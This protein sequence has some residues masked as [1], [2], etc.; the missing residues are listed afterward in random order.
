MSK[1]PKSPAATGTQPRPG[2]PMPVNVQEDDD[3]RPMAASLEGKTLAVV[4]I[5]QMVEEESE[6]WEHAPVY[7]MH[8]RVTLEDG[9]QL[10]LFRNMKTGSWYRSER[11]TEAG[12][13]A[14]WSG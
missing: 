11:P 1:K 12:P 2:T 13:A 4:A 5:D 8:Y 10:A 7:K 14:P 3:L 9:Q 6:W